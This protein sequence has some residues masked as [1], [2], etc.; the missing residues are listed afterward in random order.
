LRTGDTFGGARL[1][2]VLTVEPEQ[3]MSLARRYRY[4]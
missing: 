1:P 2:I 3:L 4:A